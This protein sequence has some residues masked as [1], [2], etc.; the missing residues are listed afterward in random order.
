MHQPILTNID[1][2]THRHTYR[3]AM[4]NERAA[5][6]LQKREKERKKGRKEVDE[7][8]V[9][10]WLWHSSPRDADPFGHGVAFQIFILTYSGLESD[11]ASLRST[12]KRERE[13]NA[14]ETRND[15][16]IF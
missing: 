12:E 4:R 5:G 9:W 15:W 11:P 3:P 6:K 14:W 1:I 13:R 16:L 2:Q 10:A 8:P 7:F